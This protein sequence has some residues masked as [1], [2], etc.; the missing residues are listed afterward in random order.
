[1]KGFLNFL[2]SD[3]RFLIG[4]GILTFG[5]VS[6]LWQVTNGDSV[7]G[8]GMLMGFLYAMAGCYVIMSAQSHLANKI[9]SMQSDHIIELMTTLKCIEM[10]LNKSSYNKKLA[11]KKQ[12][13]T[14]K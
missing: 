9:I 2:K 7:Y 6:A 1:M 8:S 11:K 3:L 10:F 13:S 5:F 4:L 12:K 14:Q